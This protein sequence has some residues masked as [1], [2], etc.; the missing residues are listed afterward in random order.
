VPGKATRT[1]IT[2]IMDVLVALAILLTIRLV[3][4]FFGQLASQEWGKGI[5]VL[6]GY[7]TFPLGIESLKTPYGGVF[8]VN[9]A[10]SIA[11]LLGVE[12]LLSLLRSRE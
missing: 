10:L 11:I 1:V 4:L 9:S 8:D 5:A 6:S 12:W 2:I 3:V 7:V